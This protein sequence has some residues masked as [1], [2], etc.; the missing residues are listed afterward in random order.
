MVRSGSSGAIDALRATLRLT[1]RLPIHLELPGRKL[2]QQIEHAV[3]RAQVA[4][5]Y[6]LLPSIQPA[7]RHGAQGGAAQDQGHGQRILIDADQLPID[8]GQGES[9]ERPA[10]PAHPARDGPAP[11]V[12]AGPLRQ[13]PL[14]AEHAA[15][16]PP[17]QRHGQQHERP[18]D[19]PEGE[20]RQHSEVVE[21]RS[22]A[23]RQRQEHR[24]Q[25]Q[26]G[27]DG[28]H[29]PLHA[30]NG[31]LMIAQEVA[32][33]SR[34]GAAGGQRSTHRVAPLVDAVCGLRA[35]SSQQTARMY[36]T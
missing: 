32:H 36:R 13:R 12:P 30:A 25:Q 18:P 17:H 4:A 34:P 11:P 21:H 9:D 3:D 2:G 22:A 5:P 6:P 33:A 7:H 16:G 24:R 19:A 29:Q 28:H 8:R 23:V 31:S 27:V 26:D 15:P 14:R 20:L 35:R 1:P 10:A